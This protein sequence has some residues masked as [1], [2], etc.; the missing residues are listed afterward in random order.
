ML[1]EDSNNGFRG[2]HGVG[3]LGGHA[4]PTAGF[5]RRRPAPADDALGSTLAQ[6]QGGGWGN[7]KAR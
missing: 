3:G 2:L 1:A 4:Q 6:V 5:S 7:D